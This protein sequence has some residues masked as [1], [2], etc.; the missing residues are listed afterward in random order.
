MTAPPSNFAFLQVEFPAPFA[1]AVKAESLV[2]SDP[3][4]ACFYAR[5]ALELAPDH[6][7]AQVNLGRL[8]HQAGNPSA[9]E[10]SYR[11]ALEFR[12]DDVTAAFNLGVALEDLGRRAEALAAYQQAL[13]SDPDFSD[14]HYN[15]AR[16][17]EQLGRDQDALRHLQIYRRLTR[18]A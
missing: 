11:R 3:R 4:T 8:A 5:R 15:L 12:P 14:A 17:C 1:A 18:R 2:H 6:V 10:A 16:L 7:D 13:A 9:A